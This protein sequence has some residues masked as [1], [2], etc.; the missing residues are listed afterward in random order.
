MPSYSLQ[1]TN[2]SAQS[3]K[4]PKSTVRIFTTI[5]IYWSFGENPT[6]SSKNCAFLAA[7]QTIELKIPVKCSCLAFVAA[8]KPGFVTVTEISS[9]RASCSA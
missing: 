5:P 6:A 7:G 9:T 4:L 1:A 8:D 2:V 3:P